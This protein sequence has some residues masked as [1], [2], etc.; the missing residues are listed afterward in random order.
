MIRSIAACLLLALPFAASAAAP[1]VPADDEIVRSQEDRERL[2]ADRLKP[3]GGLLA[4]FD[5]NGDGRISRA[6]LKTGIAAAFE[7]AD[8]NSDGELT[9][10]E[11]KAW[12]DSLP[13]RDNSLAN[14]VRFDPNLDRR[15]SLAEFSA[16][17]T[18]LWADYRD[19]GDRELRVAS[20]KAPKDE[21]RE[22]RL[23]KPP[24]RESRRLTPNR[25]KATSRRPPPAGTSTPA[26]H[27]AHT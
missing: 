1:A 20:L 27:P 22:T 11:Q 18:N 21:R 16:V 26:L 12:A 10:L 4:S 14:P 6:E 23:G 25:K 8:A 19:D 9:A 13:T 15:V 2:R 7:A 3:G 24:C 17:I 5:S